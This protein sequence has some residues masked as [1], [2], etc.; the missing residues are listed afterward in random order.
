M[1]SGDEDDQDYSREEELDDQADEEEEEEEEDEAEYDEE[2]EDEEEEMG[3]KRPKKKPRHGGFILDEAEVDDEVEED[4]EWEDGAE[5]IIDRNKAGESSSSRELDSHRR[6]QMMWNYQKEDEIEEYYKRKYAE[7]TAAE[8]GL[9]D[10]DGDLPDDIAQ[11]AFMPGVKDPNLWMVKCRIGEEKSTVLQIMRKF[12]AYSTTEE[13]LLIKSVIAPEGIKGYIYIEAYKQTHVKQAITGIGNLRLGLYKQTMVPINEMTDVLKVTK[14]QASIKPGTWVRLKRSVYKDDLAQVDYVDH[15]QGQVHL[16][17]IPRID[18]TRKRGALKTT[19]TDIGK[20]KRTKRPAAKLFDI[21]AIRSI[22]GEVSNDGDFVIFEG[23]RYRRG[24]LYKSFPLNSLI[25]NGVKPSLNELEKFE[26]HPEGVELNESAADDE[27]SHGICSGDNVEV[28]EGELVHLQGKVVAVDGSK[29][30]MIPQHDDLK[31]PLEFQAHELKK[32]FRV[33]DHVKVM[34]GRYEGDTGLVVRVL[35]NQIILFSDLSM[36]EIKVL[37][38]DLQLS[39]DMA[40]GVDSLGQYQWGDLVQLDGQ[41]VGVIVRLEKENF[42]ILDMHGKLIHVKHQAVKQKRDTR[43]AVSLDC[44]QSQIQVKDHVEVVDGPHSGRK[45][46]IRHLY[47]NYAFIHDRLLMENGGIFVCKTRN[48]QLSGGSRSTSVVSTG[49]GPAP[50]MSPRL[51]SPAHSGGGKRPFG[52]TKGGRDRSD[53]DLIGKTI[54]I[55]QGPYKGHIGIVKDAM[56]TTAR[57]EL[58]STCQ[59]INV[60]KSRVDVVGGTTGQRTGSAS[61][62]SARTPMYGSQTPSYELGGRT[63]GRGGQTPMHDGSR[64]PMHGGS[65]VWDPNTGATPRPN[66]DDDAW[67]GDNSGNYNNPP[68]PGF[69]GP[70][71][72]Q[73]GAY[74]PQTPGMYTSDHTYSPYQPVPSPSEASYQESAPS[75]A[76]GSFMSPNPGGY[77]SGGMTPSPQFAAYSPMVPSPMFNPQTPG[78]GMDQIN[79]DWLTTDI[80]VRIKENPDGD[81]IGQTGEITGINGGMVS[82]FLIREDRVVNCFPYQLEPISPEPKDRIKVIF[83][84]EREQ[85]GVLLSIDGVDGVCQMDTD[86]D[87]KVLH[88][89]YL[90]KMKAQA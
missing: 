32:Y 51:S 75:P 47:R 12:I 17:L 24:F 10:A 2:E 85:T 77:G 27:E 61:T 66:F 23:N 19:E 62:Y 35:E 39:P 20:R 82:V 38:K 86:H 14:E 33:G 15:G 46:E 58:H 7:T 36:H 13:P 90:C 55:I 11:Q 78:T 40:T 73:A 22:G 9:Y 89:R 21:D 5:D 50:F 72:P 65:S 59:V 60:D 67:S 28:C 52:A 70:D 83:G 53:L 1:S 69:T 18:Y 29:I 43:K 80:V 6:L 87:V 25:I 34:A 48:I 42:Q 4:E 56:A 8:K 79:I 41:T 84:E 26:E 71:T 16:K 49:R 76:S 88:L 45:G 30:T 37:P 68:T 64:T 63:P 54:K 3:R 74:T 57:V 81:L 31:D 44:D